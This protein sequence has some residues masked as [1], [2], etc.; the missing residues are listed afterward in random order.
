MNYIGLL[1]KEEI[2]ILCKIITGKEFREIFKKNERE[3]LKIQ[4]GFRAKSLTEQHALLIAISNVD[5]PF[6]AMRINT[7]VDNWI[8]EIQENIAKLEGDGLSHGA[9]LATTMLDSFFV[10]NVDLY[11]K[12]TGNSLDQDMRSWLYERMEDIKSERASNAAMSDRIKAL[13]EENRHMSE[14]VETAQRNVDAMKAEYEG[15]V[16]EIA[17][18]KERLRADLET[19]RATIAELQVIPSAIMIDDADYLVQYDDTNTSALPSGG[20]RKSVV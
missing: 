11:F 13:E 18:D 5:K 20:D 14:E 2:T 1:T 19:A 10:N 15:K 16:Q 7:M 3:F 4:K 9:A 17:R 6:I 8:K 12:L